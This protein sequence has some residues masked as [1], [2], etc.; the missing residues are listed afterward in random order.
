MDRK[1]FALGILLSAA[2]FVSFILVQ[3]V[4]SPQNTAPA[5]RP[6][7]EQARAPAPAVQP[8]Q[9]VPL[10]AVLGSGIIS[11]TGTWRTEVIREETALQPSCIL[12]VTR[13]GKI[14]FSGF[15]QND[16][17]KGR[18][19]T[20][21]GLADRCVEPSQGPFRLIFKL[22][23]ATVAGRR[24]SLAIEIKGTF[25]GDVG[26][27]AGVRTLNHIEI[28]SGSGGLAGIKGKGIAVGR[29]TT[30]ESSNVYYLEIEFP[31]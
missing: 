21:G 25:T 22:D 30:T 12:Y 4:V 10:P 26:T 11:G 6:A 3:P 28:L 23:D 15:I 8:Q 20:H 5:K 27:P 18:Y 14:T 16:L 13:I 31:G 1:S 9:P 2:V 24:G 19:E 29:S 7:P 17:E